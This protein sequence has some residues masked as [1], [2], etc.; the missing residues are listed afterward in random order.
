MSVNELD[1]FFH[2]LEASSK[3]EIQAG[4]SATTS[5]A[6]YRKKMSSECLETFSY[7]QKELAQLGGTGNRQKV[8]QELDFQAKELENTV[9]QTGKKADKIKA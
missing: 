8:L 9:Q 1:T 6:A 7:L 5:A 4:K 2:Q 3:A